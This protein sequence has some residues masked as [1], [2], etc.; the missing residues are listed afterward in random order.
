[1]PRFMRLISATLTAIILLSAAMSA[2]AMSEADEFALFLDWFEGEYDNH[3]QV[4]QQEV[5]EVAEDDRL[6]HIHH[7]FV[8]V[9]APAIGDNVFFVIQTMDDDMNKVYRQRIY[10][11]TID[12]E[13]GAIKLVIY[14]MSD[15][16]KYRNTWQDTS[17]IKDITMDEVSTLAGCEVF[18]KHNGEF[19]D[20]YMKDKA[21]HFFSK[22][23]NKEIY[24]TDTLRLT[25]SEIWISDKAFDAEGNKI[26]GRDV[27][28]KNR[29][30]RKFEAW[31]AVKKN[32]VDP[33]YEGDD[34]FFNSKV[35][36]HNEGHTVQITDDEGEPTGYSVQLAQLTYQNTKTAILKLGV[37]ED[38]SGD[39]LVYT[40]ASTG[41]D[42]IGI[43]LRWLQAGL[44]AVEE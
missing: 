4:W 9:D 8:A 5:D 25:D 31:M 2:S 39:T 27:P 37:I 3:E 6:E 44:T 16:E 22:R 23:S 11:F 18:W 35:I 12:Q 28:H 32:K 15:E 38:S 14:R 19:F 17:L 41:S 34:M 1:M 13:E 24:I 10:D 20:G 36:M 40:W 30:V 33:S 26:F 42:R 29:K 43:N 7:R 21:C